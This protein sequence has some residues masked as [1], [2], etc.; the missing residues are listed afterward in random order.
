[1]YANTLRINEQHRW[2]TWYLHTTW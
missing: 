2:F 1:M